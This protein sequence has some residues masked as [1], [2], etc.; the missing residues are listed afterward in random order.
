V[1]SYVMRNIYLID[2]HL[3]EALVK[4]EET[5]GLIVPHDT[6]RSSISHDTQDPTRGLEY[7]HSKLFQPDLH[8]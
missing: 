5:K 1:L 4:I 7:Y 6:S 8:A 2:F 3:T